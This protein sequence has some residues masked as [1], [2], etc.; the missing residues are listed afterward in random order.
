MSLPEMTFTEKKKLIGELRTLE[1]TIREY[2]KELETEIKEERG[3]R[4]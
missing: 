4:K 2:R 3:I 1:S